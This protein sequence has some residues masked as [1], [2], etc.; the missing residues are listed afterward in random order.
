MGQLPESRRTQILEELRLRG[1]LRVTE[2]SER[3]GVAPVTVRRD[4]NQLAAEGV[5][6]RIHGGAALDAPAA[7]PASPLG[8]GDAPAGC[9][10]MLVPSLA[11][12]WPGIIQGAREEADERN[13][14]LLLRGTSYESTDDRAQLNH[15]IQAG[16]QGLIIAPSMTTH[17]TGELLEWLAGEGTPFVLVEREAFLPGTREAVESVNTDHLTGAGAAVRHFASMGHSR[18][19]LAAGLGSPHSARIREGWQAALEE[20]DLGRADVDVTLARAGESHFD[21]PV[22]EVVQRCLDTGTTALLVHADREAIA[23]VQYCQKQDIRVPED[24]SIIAYDD[25]VAGLFSPSLTAVRPPRHSIGRAVVSLIAERLRD[26]QRPTHRVLISPKLNVRD[27]VTRPDARPV[28][29]TPGSTAGS[30]AR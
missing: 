9:L 2:L 4:I 18:I 21:P 7:S 22:S 30:P 5:L 15:L 11:Y 3:L 19:G 27:S 26:P 10:G 14:R 6:R 17:A 28:V 16:A 13:L 23:V 24:L 20:L 29:G 1:T 8:G 25:E 12:Y